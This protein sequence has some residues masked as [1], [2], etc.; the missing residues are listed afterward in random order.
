MKAKFVLFSLLI[1]FQM[2]SYAQQGFV[3]E[4][5]DKAGESLDA[6]AVVETNESDY[7][8]VNRVRQFGYSFPKETR[9]TKISSEGVFL[10][11]ISLNVYDTI[12]ILTDLIP[13]PDIE[14]RYIGLGIV[15]L[16]NGESDRIVVMQL[17]ANLETDNF[18][19]IHIPDIVRLGTF[20][21]FIVHSED[22]IVVASNYNPNNSLLS[23][24][25]FYAR[26]TVQGELKEFVLDTNNPSL[27][28]AFFLLEDS[29]NRKYGIMR[30]TRD[31]NLGDV[32]SVYELDTELNSSFMTYIP[33][34]YKEENGSYYSLLF[35]SPNQTV[36]PYLNE[37]FLTAV[38][39]RESWRTL[40]TID[41]RSP[42]LF[43]TGKDFVYDE[44]E[45]IIFASKND[46]IEYPTY[47]SAFDFIDPNYIFYSFH[48]NM[49]P[50]DAPCQLVPSYIVI[51]KL[52]AD[53]EIQWQYYYG[54]GEHYIPKFTFATSDGG[55][56]ITG[57]KYDFNT[58]CKHDM[59]VIKLNSEGLIGLDE[60]PE[61]VQEMVVY[62]NPFH[63]RVQL[64]LPPNTCRVSVYN[65]NGMLIKTGNGNC[66]EL[67]LGDVPVGLYIVTAQTVEGKVYIQKVVKE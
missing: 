4:L 43:R 60:E 2:F 19:T 28:G 5:E 33:H 49:I 35:S 8:L 67:F 22:D 18:H 7:L 62:P 27:L 36:R 44:N 53:L 15:G 51:N 25:L 41:D 21:K 58:Q 30:F 48:S 40:S 61:L 13:H 37:N 65:S 45:S 39:V 38:I 59:F 42:I 47:F 66:N 46:T 34:V 57:C 10:D 9:I 55:C 20:T 12:V 50:Q 52:N 14:D 17:N 63:D 16:E 6:I 26:I 24:P 54:R 3:F 56:L 31:T 32:L 23:Q 64:L 1:I 11:E 29:I